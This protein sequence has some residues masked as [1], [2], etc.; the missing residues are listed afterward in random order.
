[1]SKALYILWYACGMK[2]TCICKCVCA[3]GQLVEDSV[4]MVILNKAYRERE[5]ETRELVCLLP[6]TN[7]G[8]SHSNCLQGFLLIVSSHVFKSLFPLSELHLLIVCQLPNHIY[9]HIYENKK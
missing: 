9:N 8:F 6:R 1:M 3:C 2:H 5:R 7:W 4:A